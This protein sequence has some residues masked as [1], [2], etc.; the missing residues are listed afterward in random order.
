VGSTRIRQEW[1]A[2]DREVQEWEAHEQDKSG[3]HKNQYKLKARLQEV[4]MWELN[5]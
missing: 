2:Q 4:E 3:K 1:E 5:G